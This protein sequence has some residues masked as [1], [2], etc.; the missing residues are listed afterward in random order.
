MNGINPV[1]SGQTAVATKPLPHNTYG[2]AVP[3]PTSGKIPVR[4]SH[5]QQFQFGSHSPS[6]KHQQNLNLGSIQERLNS[7]KSNSSGNMSLDTAQTTAL[8]NDESERS[9]PTSSNIPVRAKPKTRMSY[10]DQILHAAHS[11]KH[12]DHHQVSRAQPPSL[13]DSPQASTQPAPQLKP[14]HPAAHQHPPKRYIHSTQPRYPQRPLPAH[15]DPYAARREEEEIATER[16][17]MD[18]LISGFAA[19]FLYFLGASIILFVRNVGDQAVVTLPVTPLSWQMLFED[20]PFFMRNAVSNVFGYF[21]QYAKLFGYFEG[22]GTINVEPKPRYLMPV[23]IIIKLTTIFYF[24]FRWMS[25]DSRRLFKLGVFNKLYPF[26][27]S[28]LSG[29]TP[30]EIERELHDD[31]SDEFPVATEA[32]TGQPVSVVHMSSQTEV[33]FSAQIDPYFDDEDEDD[34]SVEL[35]PFFDGVHKPLE[36]WYYRNEDK[37]Y[38]LIRKRILPGTNLIMVLYFSTLGV[39]DLQRPWE[40]GLYLLGV[41]SMFWCMQTFLSILDHNQYP[42]EVD[43][44]RGRQ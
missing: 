16:Y 40:V 38:S 2:S 29:K 42:P 3:R 7:L 1:N 28:D 6:Q 24:H 8:T 23:D 43:S 26:G 33:A 21:I 27:G 19:L 14:I 18:V 34:E 35:I 41:M 5:S 17:Y 36:E 25:W 10:R 39:L 12:H 13:D 22:W 20:F 11:P 32:V 15:F 31:V 37:I 4:Q 9:L 30:M 44:A